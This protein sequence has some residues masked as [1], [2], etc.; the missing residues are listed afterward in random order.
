MVGSGCADYRAICGIGGAA[1]GIL[2][3]ARLN[4][5]KIYSSGRACSDAAV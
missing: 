4:T 5:V 1:T 2:F 3:R